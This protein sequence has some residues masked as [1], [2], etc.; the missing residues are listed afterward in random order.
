MYLVHIRY[1]LYTPVSQG[2]LWTLYNVQCT[3]Y[4]PVSSIFSRLISSIH[5][6]NHLFFTNK[7]TKKFITPGHSR[8]ENVWYTGIDKWNMNYLYLWSSLIIF[9]LLCFNLDVLQFDGDYLTVTWTGCSMN[10]P[11][12]RFIYTINAL[13]WISE[14]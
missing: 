5:L 3:L 2:N 10:T 11:Q 13:L 12:N 6:L 4:I 9:I 14:F 8:V 7:Q 1:I